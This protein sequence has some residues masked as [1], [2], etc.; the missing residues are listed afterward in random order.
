MAGL[1]R[2]DRAKGV[3]LEGETRFLRSAGKSGSLK[4]E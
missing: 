1:L 2:G 4:N 3:F